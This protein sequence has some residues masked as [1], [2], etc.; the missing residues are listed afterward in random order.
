MMEIG[1]VIA[2]RFHGEL[3]AAH[4]SQPEISMADQTALDEKLA[5]AR[6]AGAGIEMLDGGDPVDT[7]LEFAR[8]RG[9]TQLFI[10]HSQRSGVWA[11]MW[12]NPVERLIRGSEGMDVRIFPQ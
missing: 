3:I 10:G 11:R 12:G 5:I 4:V 6:A 2:D 1:R 9:I 8:A 7:I